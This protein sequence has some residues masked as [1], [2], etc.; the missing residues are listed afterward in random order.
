[1]RR[2]S[3]VNNGYNIDEVND[4]IDVVIR[5]LEKLTGMGC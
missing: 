5:K 3:I 1:M 2:F 4:F